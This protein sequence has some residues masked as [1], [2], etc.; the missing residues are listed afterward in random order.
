MPTI[1]IIENSSEL[2]AGTRG[3]G[4]GIGALKVAAQNKKSTYFTQYERFELENEND[5]LHIPSDFDWGK[6]IDGI[7]RI[8]QQTA[9]VVAHVLG[10]GDFP[11]VLA[12]DH[13]S[14]G[15][16]IAGIKKQFPNKR[17]GVVWI[18]AHA[19][20]H[21]PYTSPSGNVHGMPLATALA[22]DNKECQRNEPQIETKENWEALKNLSAAAP[23]VKPEDLV[24]IAVRDTEKPEDEL[25]AR[26]NITNH[27]VEEVRQKGVDAIAALVKDQLKDCDMVYISFDVDSMDCDIVSRGTGTPVENGLTPE[28]AAAFM[29]IFANWNKVN[30]IEVVEVNPCLDDKINKMAETT[31]D[32]IEEFTKIL[33]NRIQ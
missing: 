10:E 27:T 32:I 26:N 6:Y 12:G 20:L 3:A 8:Y 25:M 16:T 4:L 7:L 22:M 5:L 19:D 29:N 9:D 17:L 30:C 1:K 2:G 11:L 33:E 14:A 21:S 24:F 13:S 28:E 23:N 18:D 15:G 31:F